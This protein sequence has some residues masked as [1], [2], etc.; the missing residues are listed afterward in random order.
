MDAVAE[1]DSIHHTPHR[2]G[3]LLGPRLD[4]FHHHALRSSQPL[5][6]FP[7]RRRRHVEPDH[8][9]VAPP[10]YPVHDELG[11]RAA[12]ARYIHHG[13]AALE[14]RAVQEPL[15]DLS[16]EGMLAEGFERKVVETHDPSL[17]PGED[18]HACT[19]STRGFPSG[20]RT[21][22]WNVDSV[23]CLSNSCHDASPA[24]IQEALDIRFLSVPQDAWPQLKND[25][26]STAFF[27]T[28]G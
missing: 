22:V 27:V 20:I 21:V 1:D 9:R 14:S 2:L 26:A 10:T 23:E 4:E 3:H 6:R 7:E 15:V 25:S 16:V 5:P 19:T 8:Y 13:P 12:A 17:A 28:R 24:W 18:A 11:H